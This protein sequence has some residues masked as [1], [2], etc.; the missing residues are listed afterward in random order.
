MAGFPEGTP[1]V[2]E[3]FRNA[4]GSSSGIRIPVS[5]RMRSAVSRM[6]WRI[7]R[8]G[9]EE[10]RHIADTIPA[11]TAPPTH[12]DNGLPGTIHPMIP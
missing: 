7:V 11:R 3:A 6:Y 8:S 10:L 1:A 2:A 12:I 5:A 4:S 9:F